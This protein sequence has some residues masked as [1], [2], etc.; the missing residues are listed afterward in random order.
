ML[1]LII[2]GTS[3]TELCADLSAC[4]SGPSPGLGL[5][6]G[7]HRFEI[8]FV[9]VLPGALWLAFLNELPFIKQQLCA[10]HYNSCF[11]YLIANSCSSPL[12][13]PNLSSLSYRGGE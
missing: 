10:R 12:G 4:L 3:L 2:I 13:N 1:G 7:S 6:T 5:G 11:L 8:N 9:S